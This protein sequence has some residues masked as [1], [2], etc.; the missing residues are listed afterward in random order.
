[1][2]NKDNDTS[3]DPAPKYISIVVVDIIL[4][5]VLGILTDKLVNFIGDILGINYEIGT[6]KTIPIGFY[7]LLIIQ[8]LIVT[9]VIYTM[10]ELAWHMYREPQDNYSY[11]I[12]FVS[13]YM[14]SQGNFQKLLNAFIHN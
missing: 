5:L 7:F 12:I 10:K 13:V 9:L 11:D 8:I 1:M 3:E 4:A 2:V 6:R 14:S